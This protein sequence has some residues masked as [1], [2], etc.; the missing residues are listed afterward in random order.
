MTVRTAQVAAALA[1]LCLFSEE[2]KFHTCERDHA[3]RREYDF[4]APPSRMLQTTSPRRI[5]V[6]SSGSAS[7]AG[8]R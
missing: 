5:V 2:R 1:C 8:G 6:R 3:A 7:I 4:N